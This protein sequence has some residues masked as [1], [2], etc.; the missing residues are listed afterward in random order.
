MLLKPFDVE[1]QKAW[2][3]E[4]M[5]KG[6]L[7][8][9]G[10]LELSLGVVSGYRHPNSPEVMPLFGEAVAR[11]IGTLPPDK[12]CHHHECTVSFNATEQFHGQGAALDIAHLPDASELA[13][14]R[15]VIFGARYSNDDRFLSP[16]GYLYGMDLHA[17]VASMPRFEANHGVAFAFDVLFG[18]ALGLVLKRLW[19]RYFRW[20]LPAIP[21]HAGRPALAYLWLVGI[22][23][24]YFGVVVLAMVLVVCLYAFGVWFSPLGMALGMAVDAFVVQGVEEAQHELEHHR[25]V[26]L[27]APR[28]WVGRLLAGLPCVLYV[29]TVGYALASLF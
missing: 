24:I 23:V 16:V 13:D 3:Q 17:A 12:E 4:R 14:V 15:H 27:H 21:E 28:S 20:K 18:I 11:R 22:S 6:A 7:F 1:R 9:D 19:R 29:G 10:E 8:A 25:H 2:M 5:S 26:A